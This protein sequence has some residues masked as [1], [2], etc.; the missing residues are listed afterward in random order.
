MHS[1]RTMLRWLP[2]SRSTMPTIALP[3]P[4]TSG[5]GAG[6]ATLYSTCFQGGD[7][8]EISMIICNVWQW[9]RTMTSESSAWTWQLMKSM[10]IYGQPQQRGGK[11][12]M[13]CGRVSLLLGWQV[14]HATHTQKPDTINPQIPRRAGH[15][16]WEPLRRHVGLCDDLQDGWHISF[17]A[18]VDP[19]GWVS[20]VGLA[21]SDF[22]FIGTAT[23][24]ETTLCAPGALWRKGLEAHRDRSSTMSTVGSFNA[25]LEDR[26]HATFQGVHRSGLQWQLQDVGTKRVPSTVF[27]RAGS[28]DPWPARPKFSILPCG[29]SPRFGSMAWCCKCSPWDD[30]S[31]SGDATWS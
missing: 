23:G 28:G 21:P 18:S 26:L 9:A 7:V 20:S 3:F 24:D 1:R 15:V 31:G 25:E 12:K 11:W 16:L 30:P 4:C 14:A 6:S 29:R 10:E 19:G 5:Q 13:D 17:R 8:M 27:R 2:R 22:S